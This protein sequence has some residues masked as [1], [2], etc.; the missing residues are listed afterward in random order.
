MVWRPGRPLPGSL[1][2][3]AEKIARLTALKEARPPRQH[4]E[5]VARLR[6]FRRRLQHPGLEL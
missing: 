3:A 5:R 6:P 2:E 4:R 1:G